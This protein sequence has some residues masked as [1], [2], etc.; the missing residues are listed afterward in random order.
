MIYTEKLTQNFVWYRVDKSILDSSHDLF[1]CGGYIP[2]EKSYCDTEIFKDLE[3]DIAEF[4][5]QGNIM[6]LGDFNGRT[7]KL[8]DSVSKEGNTFI[9]DITETCYTPKNRENFD[10]TCS[11]QP[12]KIFN[13]AM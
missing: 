2:P 12:W 7:S 5:T 10:N 9:G 6:L 1:I 8:E 3:N 11:E 4:S 13:R